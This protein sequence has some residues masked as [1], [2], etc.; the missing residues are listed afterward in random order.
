MVRDRA[1]EYELLV[2]CLSILG[3]YVSLEFL[4][5]FDPISLF[6]AFVRLFYLLNNL[7]LL[8]SIFRLYTRANGQDPNNDAELKEMFKLW[9]VYCFGILI[10]SFGRI[11]GL[12]GLDLKRMFT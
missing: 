2:L 10:W 8:S 4:K 1:I 5:I 12:Y 6:Y 11:C 7:G 3:F 9:A